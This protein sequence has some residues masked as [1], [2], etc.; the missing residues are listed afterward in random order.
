[1]FY[2]ILYIYICSTCSQLVLNGTFV[3][4]AHKQ[5]ICSN[6]FI[7]LPLCVGNNSQH[8]QCFELVYDIN[9]RNTM[10]ISDKIDKNKGYKR[11]AS[12]TCSLTSSTRYVS[13]IDNVGSLHSL[14]LTESIY[15]PTLNTSISHVNVLEL[16][17]ISF[18]YPQQHHTGVVGF[19]HKHE[20]NIDNLYLKQ[21]ER[22]RI[23][24][25]TNYYIHYTST[26]NVLF[27][28]GISYYDPIIN[29]F[30]FCKSLESTEPYY[31]SLPFPWSCN[32]NYISYKQQPFIQLANDSVVVT[33]NTM[34][35]GIYAPWKEGIALLTEYVSASNNKCKV[36]VDNEV[37]FKEKGSYV[38]C[39]RNYDYSE[40][41]VFT[42]VNDDG[43]NIKL[44]P[45]DVF[46]YT[47]GES[48]L[49]V[50]K[51]QYG[52]VLDLNVLKRY[53]VFVMGTQNKIGFKEN[54]VFPNTYTFMKGYYP[55]SCYECMIMFNKI[56]LGMLVCG[57]VYLFIIKYKVL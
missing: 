20:T 13:S 17:E 34:I 38:K 49:K 36:V 31:T 51:Y 32:F 47:T 33:F 42:F 3:Y 24:S 55:F 44:Y 12:L 5:N 48:Y 46:N 50:K 14:L 4:N 26:S 7:T 15:F 16:N 28:I 25:N 23:I 39:N 37:G 18:S 56:V 35:N 10:L 29:T 22:K 41:P 1:M 9:G 52:W 11:N 54:K 43:V 8:A 45:V 19:H 2:F 27:T 30:T 21:L 53:D 6:V 57:I 40:L